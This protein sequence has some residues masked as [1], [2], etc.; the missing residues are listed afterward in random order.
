MQE[1]ILKLI[2]LFFPTKTKNNLE[3]H[4]TTAK[5]HQCC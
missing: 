1:T 3:V 5:T 2:L 4:V